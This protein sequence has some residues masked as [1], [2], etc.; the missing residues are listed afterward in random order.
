MDKHKLEGFVNRYS[1]GGEI[2]SVVIKSNQKELSVK[3]ISDDKSLL[4]EVT[5][6]DIDVPDGSYPIYTTSQFKQLLSVLDDD[7]SV[8]QGV[9]SLKLSDN[10]TS[11]N[12]MLATESVIPTVPPLK[13]LPDFDVEV[14]LDSNVI[15]RFIKSKGA[16]TDS[17][18]FTF[19]S[20]DGKSQIVLGYSTVN[21]NRISILVDAKTQGDVEPISFSAKYLKQILL[22][23]KSSNDAVLKISTDGLS[24]VM[25]SDSEYVSKYY[26]VQ[27]K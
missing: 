12:Y 1:L 5:A 7:V 9:G 24:F 2:E 19:M 10:T 26:L 6:H 15:S 4:G 18:T 17:D 11:V 22:A 8:E 23:N 20:K 25:F 21:T 3:M 14:I 27:Q 13:M 16:L